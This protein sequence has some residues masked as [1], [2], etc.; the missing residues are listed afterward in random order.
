VVCILNVGKQYSDK[1]ERKVT[2]T[3][4]YKEKDCHKCGT[5]IVIP[6]YDWSPSERN[7]CQ[8]CAMS[9]L[10][11]LP[12]DEELDKARTEQAIG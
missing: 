10:G 12:D 5:P 3:S 1:T 2:M 7:F 6:V 11:E 8:P 4:K 9:Y